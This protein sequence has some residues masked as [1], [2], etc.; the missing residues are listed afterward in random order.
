MLYALHEMQSSVAAPWRAA[1]RHLLEWSG[2]PTNPYRGWPLNDVISATSDLTIRLT[3][4]YPKRPFAIDRVESGGKSY[5]VA[6]A[7]VVDKAFCELRHFVKLGAKNAGPKVLLVAPLSGHHATLL[8]DTVRTMLPDFDV[9]ITDWKDARDVPSSKGAFGFDDYVQYVVDFFHYF[10]ERIHV[11]S[12]CQPTVP[13]LCAVARM[14]AAKDPLRPKAMIMMGG[15]IDT[16]AHPSQVNEFAKGHSLDW[17]KRHLIARVPAQYPGV[18]RRVYPGFLQYYGFV[19]MNPDRHMKAHWQYF[20]QLVRGD[21]SSTEHHRKFYD[22]YNAVLDL[23]AEYYLETV[24]H[25]F[26]EHSLPLGKMVVKGEKVDLAAIKD[27]RL[28]SVEGE[29]D[30]ISCPGQTAAA[31]GMCSKIPASQKE[32]YVAPQVGHYGIFAGSKFRSMIYPKM[33]AFLQKK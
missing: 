8:R 25:V 33:K 31:L 15:P 12:V 32:M 1:A 24:E 28:M 4:E 21:D 13:V 30:D 9:Y 22:E 29:L 19:A 23:P 18:G 16:R 27:V 14:S 7:V 11:V 2:A 5:P 3:Q 20:N 17:F 26:Q 6:E 10:D